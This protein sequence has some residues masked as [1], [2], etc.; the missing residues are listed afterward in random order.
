MPPRNVC[1]G[2]ILLIETIYFELSVQMDA[3]PTVR[4]TAVVDPDTAFLKQACAWLPCSPTLDVRD[5]QPEKMSK[6]H[7]D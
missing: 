2:A 4:P 1:A 5:W 3:D 6:L 7:S